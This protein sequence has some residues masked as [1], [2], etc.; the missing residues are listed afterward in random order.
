MATRTT[1]PLG[2]H[3]FA[4]LL[5][6]GASVW[7]VDDRLPCAE[8]VAIKGKEI[9]AVGSDGE[10]APLAGKD[11]RVVDL[12]GRLVL[13]GFNDCHTHF[14]LETLVAATAF[15]LYGVDSLEEAQ[16]RLQANALAHPESEWLYGS[17]WSNHL[18][19][20]EWPARSVLDAVENQR[21]VAIFD[22]DWHTAWVNTA[23][24]ERLG[25]DDGGAQG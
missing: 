18:F 13:P 3:P 5:L 11:T 15:S 1:E 16:R 10:L 22:I 17:R 12:Q 8:A 2:N 24:L 19:D 4:D 23:A 6:R 7:T 9:I 20:G 21:P 14:L 25:Y